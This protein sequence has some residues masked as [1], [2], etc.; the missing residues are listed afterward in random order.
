MDL[1]NSV[2]LELLPDLSSLRG[3]LSV[4]FCA[5]LGSSK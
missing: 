3:N 4:T 5:G 1:K 2:V